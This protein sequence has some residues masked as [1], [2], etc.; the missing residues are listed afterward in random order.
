MTVTWDS[1]MASLVDEAATIYR[2]GPKDPAHLKLAVASALTAYQQY[3]FD[4]ERAVLRRRMF[5]ELGQRGGR[6][7]AA[8]ARKKKRHPSVQIAF[9]FSPPKRS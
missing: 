6:K 4:S 8:L 3:Y 2:H 7:T 5:Q 1:L 9:H